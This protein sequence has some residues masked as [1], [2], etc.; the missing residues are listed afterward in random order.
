MY[1]EARPQVARKGAQAAFTLLEVLVA[2]ALSLVVVGAIVAFQSFQL[3]TL[4]NQAEQID[5]Q[6][7]AR[8]VV[9]LIAREARKTGRNPECKPA[10]GGLA[11]AKTKRMRLQ[12]DLDGDGLISG[13]NEDVTYGWS[14][15]G[16][17][18]VRIDHSQT[19]GSGVLVDN[20][21]LAGSAFHYFDGNG[22]ELD[23]S[24]TGLDL[25]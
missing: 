6:G 21:N 16:N 5:I 13:D 11:E 20:V 23:A 7:T 22:S 12:T 4:R 9:D 2:L 15:A 17:A 18:L 8:S 24:G 14:E 19:A 3:T 10:I 1:P 25:A